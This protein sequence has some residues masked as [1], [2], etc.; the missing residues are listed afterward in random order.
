[1]YAQVALGLGGCSRGWRH[2]STSREQPVSLMGHTAH[3]TYTLS[4]NIFAFPV[5]T[6]SPIASIS[7]LA[8][9][10]GTN[11]KGRFLHG[12]T[13]RVLQGLLTRPQSH[14]GCLPGTERELTFLE[15]EP[16]K[17]LCELRS[18]TGMADTHTDGPTHF[19]NL[20]AATHPSTNLKQGVKDADSET[21]V[22]WLLRTFLVVHLF[23]FLSY[24]EDLVGEMA[25]LKY[26]TNTSNQ[27]MTFYR[28]NR[29]LV[30][31]EQVGNHTDDLSKQVGT[32]G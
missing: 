16:Q 8:S 25:T 5:S 26:A 14:R 7:A 11:L 4:V 3:N 12:S 10:E 27:L 32:R 23:I 29:D 1:M 22:P 15:Q 2:F 21:V 19:S 17:G 9:P 31:T 6:L 30:V 13:R 28:R 24:H 18:I 20:L